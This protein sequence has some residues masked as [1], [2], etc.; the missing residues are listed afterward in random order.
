M[1]R[2]TACAPLLF[3]AGCAGGL[4]RF[5]QPSKAAAPAAALEVQGAPAPM[6]LAVG[7]ES[8]MVDLRADDSLILIGTAED[9]GGLKDMVLQGNA[10]VTCTDPATGASYTKPTGFLRRHVPGSAPGLRAPSRRDSRFVLRG[11]DIARL[12]PG[13]RLDSAIGQARVQAA[14]V[15]GGAAATPQLQFRIAVT[16]VAAN[17]IPMP[18]PARTARPSGPTGFAPQGSAGG[19]GPASAA[20][21]E[22]AA[23]SCL[24]MC[25]RSAAPGHAAE[26]RSRGARGA[27]AEAAGAEAR[28]AE[29]AGGEC[30]D[31]PVPSVSPPAGAAPPTSRVASPRPAQ[32]T[33]I[34]RI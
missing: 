21:S 9:R 33:Q 19:S 34:R 28:G 7:G 6:R 14:N 10:L 29:G 12:C 11:G 32:R 16:E 8:R 4:A 25:P 26:A 24:R 3:L 17:A 30:L 13:A 31:P 20:V 18:S 1:T 2:L 22:G 15:R 23:A 5:H 27:A